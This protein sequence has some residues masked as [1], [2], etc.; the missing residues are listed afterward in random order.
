MNVF[1]SRKIFCTDKKFSKAN[2]T[3]VEI[4]RLGLIENLIYKHFIILVAEY[5]VEKLSKNFI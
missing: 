4:K 3:I 1:L 5:L 2:K